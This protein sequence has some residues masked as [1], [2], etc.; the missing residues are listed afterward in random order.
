MNSAGAET[1]ASPYSWPFTV[2]AGEIPQ[3]TLPPL[4]GGVSPGATTAYNIYLSGPTGSPTSVIRYA[5]GVTTPTFNLSFAAA[6]GDTVQPPQPSPATVAPLVQAFVRRSYRRAPGGGHLFRRLHLYLFEW[7][8]DGRKSEFRL[9][10]CGRRLYSPGD[11]TP[12][13][14]RRDGL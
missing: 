13:T 11:A 1:Y 6:T 8:Q 7:H 5:A 4:P 2:T 9:V 10:Y 12:L 3:V 14:A